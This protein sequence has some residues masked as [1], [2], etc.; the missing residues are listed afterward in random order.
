[1]HNHGPKLQVERDASSTKVCYTDEE[2]P[3]RCEHDRRQD[4]DYSRER[5]MDSGIENVGVEVI[6]NFV[7]EFYIV[8][9]K[10][11]R[12]DFACVRK[13]IPIGREKTK[14][15]GRGRLGLLR[16]MPRLSLCSGTQLGSS[17]LFSS[18]KNVVKLYIVVEE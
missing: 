15:L 11:A 4:Y 3:R 10:S 14:K 8:P 5:T 16:N 18:V 12:F 2:L 6:L 13:I 1:M 17:S 9:E 7:V